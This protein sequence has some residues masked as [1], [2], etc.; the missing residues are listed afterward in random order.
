M[1]HQKFQRPV[2]QKTGLFVVH[3]LLRLSLSSVGDCVRFLTLQHRQPGAMPA[4][5][6]VACEFLPQEQPGTRQ[7][8]GYG[9]A[10]SE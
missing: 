6:G 2:L 8:P 3:P 7:H 4:P 10:L 5:A 9:P 1:R